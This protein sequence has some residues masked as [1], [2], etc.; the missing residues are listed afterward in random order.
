MFI[1]S[2]FSPNGDGKN[3][4]FRVRGNAVDEVYLAV[5]DRWGE[6]VFESF[7]ASPGWDGTHKG[8]VLPPDVYGYYLRVLC[9]GGEEFIRKGNISLLR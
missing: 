9:F 5:Y 7:E 1:P 3:D 2:G 8:K 4:F 6:K